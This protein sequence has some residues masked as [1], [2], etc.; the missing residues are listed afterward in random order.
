[1]QIL[2]QS[3]AA[4]PSQSLSFYESLNFKVI[5]NENPVIVSDGQVHIEIN[6]KKFVRAGIKVFKENWKKD[7]ELLKTFTKVHKTDSGFLCSDPSNCWIYLEEGTP[8]VELTKM[9]CFSSLGNFAGMSLESMDIQKSIDIWACLGFEHSMGAIENGWYAMTEKNGFG[10]SFMTPNSCPH[11]F[12][13]PSL[14]YFNGGKN[15]PVIDKIKLAGI[16]IAEEI[17]TFNKEGIVDNVIVKDP[18]GY[19][20][21]IFND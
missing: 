18:G 4:K 8:S 19:G 5:S 13:N 1:M 11:Q 15:L 16:P 14:T 20:F 21:F 12:Y 17:S 2:I 10:V 7:V 9:E 3:P 6:P